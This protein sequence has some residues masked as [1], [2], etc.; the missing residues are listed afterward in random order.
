MDIKPKIKTRKKRTPKPK[1]NVFYTSFRISMKLHL[2]VA[3]HCIPKGILFGIFY[4]NAAMEKMDRD[5]KDEIILQE[6]KNR[7]N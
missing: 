4:E 7:M 3:E 1:P 5:K 6:A 2:K